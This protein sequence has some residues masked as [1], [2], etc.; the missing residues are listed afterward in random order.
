[1]PAL[2]ALLLPALVPA[3]VDGVRGLFGWLFGSSGAQ[4][5]NVDDAVKLMQAETQK[6]EALAK[7]DAPASNISLWVADLRASFRYLA[8]AIIIWGTFALIFAKGLGLAIE[9][10]VIDISL[11]LTG[12]VFSF[13]FGDRMYLSLRGRK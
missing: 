13:L 4:P 7:L 5:Q 8:A 6:L 11:Q 2:L 1:M 3:A 10:S 12:S 9:D